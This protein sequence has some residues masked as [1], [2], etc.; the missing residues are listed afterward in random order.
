LSDQPPNSLGCEARSAAGGPSL[1]LVDGH[2]Y[3]YRSFYAIKGLR[4]PTGTPTN[5]IF[6]FIKAIQKLLGLN[7]QAMAVIWDGGLSADRVALVPGYKAQRPPMPSDLEVQLDGMVA[8][9]EA[10]GIGSILREGMEADD[11]IATL[12]K[13]ASA[14]GREVWIASS[15]KD[16]LQLVDDRVRLVN[17]ADPDLKPIGVAGVLAKTG[18]RP[19]QIVDYLSMVGDSVDNIK[20]L[21]GVGAKTAAKL[22]HQFGS[23]EGIVEAGPTL[24]SERLRCVVASSSDIMTRNR[25]MIRLKED[26]ELGVSCDDLAKGK[27][28]VERLR[29]LYR[30]WGFESMS[31]GLPVPAFRQGELCL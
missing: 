14:Q 30:D 18:V 29:A 21:D 27:M 5:G 7:P 19:E 24:G 28:D 12:A 20:G 17:P 23:W 26:L 4:S 9:L 3:A 8:W 31:R 2:A 1:L 13:R 10:F 6:G 22:L 16:F 15:D 11:A 25:S